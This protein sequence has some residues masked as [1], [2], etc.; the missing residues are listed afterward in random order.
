MSQNINLGNPPTSKSILSHISDYWKKIP[1]F[2][3]FINII[4]IA[5]YIPSLFFKQIPYYLANI[6]YFTL[7]KFQ[8][9]RI[10]TGT[11]L[12][13][14][15]INII[16]SLL[17][18]VDK[19]SKLEN[20]LGTV[21]YSL[22]FFMNSFIIRIIY[23]IIIII[24]EIITKDKIIKTGKINGEIHSSGFWPV[25]IC[26]LSLLCLSNPNSDVRLLCLPFEFKA[27]Y[28]PIFIFIMFGLLNNL[29]TDFEVLIGIL[30][31]FLY[32]FVLKN[33]LKISTVFVKKVENCCCIKKIA[34]IKGFVSIDTLGNKVANVVNSITEKVKN[35]TVTQGLEAFKG[36]G[37]PVG[38]TYGT[39]NTEDYT[40]VGTESNSVTIRKI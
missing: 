20:S 27:K 2:I 22:I 26:E 28:Y 8:I 37:I 10:F 23:S 30:Y 11:L 1:L 6:P 31:S 36:T 19:A 21:Q 3:K 33:K 32:H 35:V 18:W 9:W 40:G 7:L 25:I 14:S 24:Y 5:I 17:F 13:T 29:N 39:Q 16:M 38:G 12:T 4:T 34:K 15:I